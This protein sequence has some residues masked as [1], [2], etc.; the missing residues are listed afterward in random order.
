MVAKI[1][2]VAFE[3]LQIKPVDVQVMLMGGLPSF[4]IVGLPDKAV[5]ESRE[6]VR[7]ALASMGLSLPAKRITVNL[8]PADLQKEGSHFD[9]P[10][11]LGLLVA[12]EILT[13]ESLQNHVSLGELSLDGALLPVSGV[14]PVS[15]YALENDKKII[16]PKGCGHEAAWA[17]ETLEIIAAESLFSL[18]NI[19]KGTQTCPRPEIQLQDA[20]PNLTDFADVKGQEQAKRALEIAASGGHHIL[21]SGPPGSGKSMLA[22]RLAGILPKLTAREA[23]DVA[24]IHS[25][26]GFTQEGISTGTSVSLAASYC[27]CACSCGWG[28]ESTPW[29]NFTCPSRGAVY[30]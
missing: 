22:Q 27:V 10:I 24:V 18:V 2:T 4:T 20:R 29:G 7:G 12:M 1:D 6:R 28:D 16:C 5:G 30:G 13:Q 21:M 23:L 9:L 17:S 3:G 11:A 15:L 26:S 19:L 8:S 25:L 14:L